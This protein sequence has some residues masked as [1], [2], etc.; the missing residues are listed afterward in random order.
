MSEQR[1][2]VFL[3]VYI[4]ADRKAREITSLEHQLYAGHSTGIVI[5]IISSNPHTILVR[6][7]TFIT[8]SPFHR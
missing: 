8:I 7:V 1:V 3:I 5:G 2:D 4:K 6:A